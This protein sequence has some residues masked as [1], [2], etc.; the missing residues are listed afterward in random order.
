MVLAPGGKIA[1]KSQSTSCLEGPSLQIEFASD[2]R[3]LFMQ[4]TAQVLQFAGGG[5]GSAQR[6]RVQNHGASVAYS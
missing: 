4:C 3:L 2:T 5:G 6:K 1:H